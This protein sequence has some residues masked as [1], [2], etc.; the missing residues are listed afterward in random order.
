MGVVD[1]GKMFFNEHFKVIESLFLLV[2]R[3]KMYY[4]DMLNTLS[5]IWRS[6]TTF[7]SSSDIQTDILCIVVGNHSK[8]LFDHFLMYLTYIQAKQKG[9]SPASSKIY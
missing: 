4:N 2:L 7:Q 1:R 3:F 6:L 9:G 5:K 8:R